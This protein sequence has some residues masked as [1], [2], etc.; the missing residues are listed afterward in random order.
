M[1]QPLLIIT[2]GYIVGY[3]GA[4]GGLYLGTNMVSLCFLG[5][6]GA[7]IFIKKKELF[8]KYRLHIV[9]FILVALI[10]FVQ[11][12]ILENK[13]DNLYNGLTEV[14]VEG[15]V[16]SDVKLRKLQKLIYNKSKKHKRGY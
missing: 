1:K 13:F 11:I 8:L 3:I 5:L 2:V 16:V 7:L 9:L 12:K 6:G 14:R 15:A 10:S 4:I